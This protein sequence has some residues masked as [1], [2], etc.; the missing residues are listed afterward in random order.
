MKPMEIPKPS[1]A[2]EVVEAPNVERPH[3]ELKEQALKKLRLGLKESV[4][5]DIIAHNQQELIIDPEVRVEAISYCCELAQV[6]TDDHRDDFVNLYQVQA[7]LPTAKLDDDERKAVW[8]AKQKVRDG[9]KWWDRPRDEALLVLR[10]GAA[11]RVG[12]FINTFKFTKEELR[13]LAEKLVYCGFD[14]TEALN[15]LPKIGWAKPEEAK[16]LGKEVFK[17]NFEELA[18]RRVALLQRFCKWAEISEQEI[19]NPENQ[20]KVKQFI[21]EKY[22]RSGALSDTYGGKGGN[23]A[24]QISELVAFFGLPEDALADAETRQAALTALKRNLEL[25]VSLEP[26]IEFMD[27]NGGIEDDDEDYKGPIIAAAINQDNGARLLKFLSEDEKQMV[28]KE[29]VTRKVMVSADYKDA[30]RIAEGR[31]SQEE[32][33]A[34]AENKLLSAFQRGQVQDVKEIMDNFR[35][36]EKENPDSYRDDKKRMFERNDYELQAKTMMLE[37]LSQGGLNAFND[38]DSYFWRGIEFA[39]GEKEQALHQG[40]L[41]GLDD[42]ARIFSGE[43]EQIRRRLINTMPKEKRKLDDETLLTIKDK[44]LAFLRKGAVEGK[45]AYGKQPDDYLIAAGEILKNDGVGL[46]ML[47][48]Q[49]LQFLRE[50]VQQFNALYKVDKLADLH[51]A[52]GLDELIQTPEVQANVK[53]T[54]CA[55]LFQGPGGYNER[56][57]AAG[58]AYSLLT[59]QSKLELS[60]DKSLYYNVFMQLRN[61]ASQH[62]EGIVTFGYIKNLEGIFPLDYITE[63]IPEPPKPVKEI[64]GSDEEEDDDESDDEEDK[65]QDKDEKKPRPGF[66]P[67]PEVEWFNVQEFRGYASSIFGNCVYRGDLE[68]AEDTRRVIHLSQDEIMGRMSSD[69]YGMLK[70]NRNLETFDRAVE[71]FGVSPEMAQKTLKDCCEACLKDEKFYNWRFLRSVLARLDNQQEAQ[72]MVEQSLADKLSAAYFQTTQYSQG[73]YSDRYDETKKLRTFE[74]SFTSMADG[75]EMSDEQLADIFGKELAVHWSKF[76]KHQQY[77][78]SGFGHRDE[79]P[80]EIKDENV[81]KILADGAVAGA[82]E[83]IKDGDGGQANSI[84]QKF[85]LTVE[86]RQ[87]V[88]DRALADV[89]AGGRLVVAINALSR[90]FDS[91][92]AQQIAEILARPDIKDLVTDDMRKEFASG[93]VVEAF[94]IGDQFKLDEKV[95]QTPEMREAILAGV[96]QAIRQTNFGLV[97][98]ILDSAAVGIS[99]NQMMARP[100]IKAAVA[101]AVKKELADN[102]VSNAF[103]IVAQFRLGRDILQT[104]EMEQAILAAA[105]VVIKNGGYDGFRDKYDSPAVNAWKEWIIARPGIRALIEADLKSKFAKLQLDHAFNLVEVLNLG[106][107]ILET[108]EMEKA[109]ME[110]VNQAISKGHFARMNITSGSA[111]VNRLLQRIVAQPETRALIVADLKNKFAT[112]RM[113]DALHIVRE[114]QLN[115]EILQMP[116]MQKAIFEGVNKAIEKG[117]FEEVEHLIESHMVTLPPSQFYNNCYSHFA[118]FIDQVEQRNAKVITQA[119]KSPTLLLT[120][121]AQHKKADK[122]FKILDQNDFLS[123][124]LMDNPRYGAQLMMKF[125]DFDGPAKENIKTLYRFKQEIM[126]AQPELDPNSAEF[127]TLMQ[128]KLLTFK[129]NEK[130]VAAC[131]ETGVDMDNWLDYKEERHFV[132]GQENDRNF[133]QLLGGPL[134]RI[135]GVVAKYLLRTKGAINDFKDVLTQLAGPSADKQQLEDKIAAQ[136]SLIS[137]EQAKPEGERNDQKLAGMNKGLEALRRR[138]AESKGGN[139]W[140]K[141]ASEIGRVKAAFD[142]TAKTQKEIAGLEQELAIMEKPEDISEAKQIIDRTCTRFKDQFDVTINLVNNFEQVL[143]DTLAQAMSADRAQALVQDIKETLG[144]DFEHL[145]SDTGDIKR[146]FA[147]IGKADELSGLPMSVKVASRNPDLDLYLG[148]YTNCCVRIDSDYHGKQSPIADYVTDLG[149]QNVILT[150]EKNKL[151]VATAW[152]FIGFDE[153]HNRILVVDNIEANNEYITKHREQIEVEMEEYLEAYAAASNI[154]IIIQ[155]PH[156]NDLD[157][158]FKVTH[159][160]GKVGGCNRPDGYYLEAEGDEVNGGGFDDDDD[161]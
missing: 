98:Q 92:S 124:A 132:L 97:N 28:A 79:G 109:I 70:N 56:A 35:T 150:D 59:E 113:V 25:G 23:I 106:Q 16:E 54:Y 99:L 38:T 36:D 131:Q 159:V 85:E 134:K 155:G 69:L 18:N 3:N 40:L 19:A 156:H 96:S 76:N 161:D 43:H 21:R 102:R 65:E 122:F 146:V 30:F 90:S 111:T 108:Q 157:I 149:M 15:M 12:D 135:D 145:L 94:L 117:R 137:Q 78:Y 2:K 55:R 160:D 52:F 41:N 103:D 20:D 126:A 144:E 9:V 22:L 47:N 100:E 11:N 8:N 67:F 58:K 17:N 81:K 142:D 101:D 129:D 24:A 48:E 72:A 74:N 29:I 83:A 104:P 88:V 63:M 125:P 49:D 140:E 57:Q 91:Q 51:E 73:R 50:I 33:K 37:Q 34:I 107:D 119:R 80:L 45:L 60:Q 148:N 147:D 84:A 154:R 39:E 4:F 71:L 87:T 130:I 123:E 93:H 7:E 86:Q 153:R 53:Q 141:L 42:D 114:L 68:V 64:A 127:R 5:A 13:P 138:A 27:R 61:M 115:Q 89:L 95:L 77:G 120:I 128:Q 151:P 112:M 44:A 31:L 32:I 152:C 121:L 26:I 14:E 66:S 6:G 1:A 158:R 10:T 139:L 105:S 143:S 118:A 82:R 116:E 136:Q 75:F 46:A 110:G 133:S 62:G